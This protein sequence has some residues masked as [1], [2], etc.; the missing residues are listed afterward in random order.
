M[1]NA[2][3]MSCGPMPGRVSPK[4]RGAVEREEQRSGRSLS[5]QAEAILLE[6]APERARRAQVA[7]ALA[8]LI[9][10]P[11]PCWRSRPSTGR[12]RTS[13]RP[14]ATRRSARRSMGCRRWRRI[15]GWGEGGAAC[16]RPMACGALTTQR[17]RAGHLSVPS[18]P[19]GQ[20][21]RINMRHVQDQTGVSTEIGVR[22]AASIGV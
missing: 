8:Y 1:C 6:A 14:T 10:P 11:K 13:S 4:V 5:A 7:R 9:T 15:W 22:T 3:P 17:R 21:A 20:P 19:L 18:S 16:R 12:G 2:L